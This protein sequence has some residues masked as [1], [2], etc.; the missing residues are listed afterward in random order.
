MTRRSCCETKRPFRCYR[1]KSMTWRR[2][3]VYTRDGRPE[4]FLS[5]DNA[6]FVLER[7]TFVRTRGAF[8]NVCSRKRSR[9]MWRV[10]SG[11]TRPHFTIPLTLILRK[12]AVRFIRTFEIGTFNSLKRFRIFAKT[13]STSRVIFRYFLFLYFFQ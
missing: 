3:I 13:I 5:K 9:Q 2:R 7:T 12:T 10:Y 11:Q 6:N 8:S 4:R 1:R